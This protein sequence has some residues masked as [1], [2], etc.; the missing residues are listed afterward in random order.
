MGF[1]WVCTRTSLVQ[2][3]FARAYVNVCSSALEI[4]FELS[5]CVCV[6]A[7]YIAAFVFQHIFS[8]FPVEILLWILFFLL[9]FLNKYFFVSL[10]FALCCKCFFFHINNVQ[11]N[12]IHI[13]HGSCVHAD[14]N[15]MQKLRRSMIIFLF[16]RI[17][18][19]Y[20][21]FASLILFSWHFVCS[22]EFI[23]II[24]EF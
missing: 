22:H 3:I 10:F 11:L 23:F 13:L 20:P 24:M 18:S 1:E 12:N 9:F 6:R 5:V 4:V 8:F 21:F 7:W 14:W 16:S 19:R 17:F 2:R 15:I